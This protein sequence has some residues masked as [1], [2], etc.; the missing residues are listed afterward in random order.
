MKLTAGRLLDISH[1]EESV[2]RLQQMA[3]RGSVSEEVRARCY[4]SIDN[5]RVVIAAL[6]AG[7]E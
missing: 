2:R 3:A 6:R 5:L 7:D 4:W 1:R